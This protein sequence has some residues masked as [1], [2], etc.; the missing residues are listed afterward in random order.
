M[1]ESIAGAPTTVAGTLKVAKQD[2]VSIGTTPEGIVHLALEAAT[3]LEVV[4]VGT[5]IKRGEDSPYPV[6]G[7]AAISKEV[8]CS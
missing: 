8:V 3:S 4:V 1:E 7:H 6:I 5:T 2:P